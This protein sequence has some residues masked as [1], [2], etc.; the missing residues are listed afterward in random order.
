MKRNL[1]LGNVAQQLTGC[2]SNLAIYANIYILFLRKR[3]LAHE[4]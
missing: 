2:V 1:N 3:L 4:D